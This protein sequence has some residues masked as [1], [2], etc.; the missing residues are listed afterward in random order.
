LGIGRTYA[1][2]VSH[3]LTQRPQ[4]M[5]QLEMRMKPSP[6]SQS[7]IS[8]YGRPAQDRSDGDADG[9][10][11][12]QSLSEVPV[13]FLHGHEVEAVGQTPRPAPRP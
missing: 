11:L 5:T 4:S 6:V 10:Q 9:P 3:S 7:P 12:V 2:G 13:E 8:A 1:V